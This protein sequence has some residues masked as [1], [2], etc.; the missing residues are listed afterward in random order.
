MQELRDDLNEARTDEETLNDRVQ[1][2]AGHDPVETERTARSGGLV[3]PD[4]TIYRI[5]FVDPG[6]DGS[7]S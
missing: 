7:D 6:A 2:A 4:E 1:G 5:E 3:R